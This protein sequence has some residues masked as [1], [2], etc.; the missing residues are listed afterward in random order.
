M[1]RETE[2]LLDRFEHL[3]A[4]EKRA[5]TTEVLRRSLPFDSGA[6][7]DDEIAGASSAL[8]ESLDEE[9]GDSA[10]RWGLACRFR[11]GREDH[12]GSSRQRCLFGQ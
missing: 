8:F 2:G 12:A 4:E 11:L 10:A 5:F 6:T 9:H 3:P 7:D 1:S